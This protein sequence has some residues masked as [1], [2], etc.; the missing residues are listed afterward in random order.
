MHKDTPAFASTMSAKS[1]NDSKKSKGKKEAIQ[2]V[3]EEDVIVTIRADDV[4]EKIQRYIAEHKL[5]PE[6]VNRLFEFIYRNCRCSDIPVNPNNLA[7][8][9]RIVD[10]ILDAIDVA[11]LPTM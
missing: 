1:K 7:F 8:E 11:Q 10:G 2:E 3:K 6:L 9:E 5:R 4:V